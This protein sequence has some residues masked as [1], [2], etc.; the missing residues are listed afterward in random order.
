MANLLENAFR[1]S[2]AGGCV[3]LSYHEQGD[4][5]RLAVWDEGPEIPLEERELIFRKGERGST[6]RALAGRV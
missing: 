1:Y 5:L 6:G 3:G 4:A 2:R